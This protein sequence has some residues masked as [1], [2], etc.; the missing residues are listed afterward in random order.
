ME[1]NE[2]AK[3]EQYQAAEQELVKLIEEVEGVAEGDLKG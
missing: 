2:R 1:T 3:R